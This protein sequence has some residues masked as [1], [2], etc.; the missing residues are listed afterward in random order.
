MSGTDTIRQKALEREHVPG[1]GAVDE[2]PETRA[3]CS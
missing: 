2:R 1:C 3:S